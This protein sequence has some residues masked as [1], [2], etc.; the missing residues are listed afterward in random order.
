MQIQYNENME[1]FFFFQL[2]I[3]GRSYEKYAAVP[4]LTSVLS[5]ALHGAFHPCP[6][7]FFLFCFPTGMACTVTILFYFLLFA[8]VGGVGGNWNTWSEK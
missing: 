8:G 7:K 3:A 2:D 6:E 5:P 4:A 1:R